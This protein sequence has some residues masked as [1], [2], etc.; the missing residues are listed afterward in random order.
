MVDIVEGKGLTDGFK[1]LTEPVVT[2]HLGSHSEQSSP[3]FLGN[4]DTASWNEQ[5]AFPWNGKD[6]L[7]VVVG[8]RVQSPV[9]ASSH[10][11]GE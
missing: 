7:R 11:I 10:Y 6:R 8:D 3:F 4:N 5:R 1:S 2:L 9:T